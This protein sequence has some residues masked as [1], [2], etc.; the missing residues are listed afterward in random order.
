MYQEG[1]KSMYCLGL[2][3]TKHDG[4]FD[5][6]LVWLASMLSIYSRILIFSKG[7]FVIGTQF[8]VNKVIF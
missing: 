2:D 8:N 5:V 6:N 7:F 4:G 3:S 1:R